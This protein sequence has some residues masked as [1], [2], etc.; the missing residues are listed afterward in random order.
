M[1]Q[2]PAVS[3]SESVLKQKGFLSKL[4][5]FGFS[6]RHQG[7]MSLVYGDTRNSLVNRTG[8]LNNLGIDHRNLVCAKQV[9]GSNIYR[10]EKKDAGRGAFSYE[11]SILDTDAFITD[12]LNLPL[13]IFTADCL[14]VFL[15]DSQR[16]AIGLVHAGWRSSRDDIMVKVSNL[17]RSNFGS[18]P[19]NLKIIFGPAIRS[20][21]YE[22]GKEFNDFFNQGLIEKKEKL[23]LDLV[24]F[25]LRRILDSGVNEE[26]ILDTHICTACQNQDYF[27]F[28]RERKDC[29][30]GISVIMLK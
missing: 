30:R 22:V 16:P 5:S 9:H 18:D 25:N 12:Q 7:N 8:F 13:A 17:M 27:S 26:N 14:S 20:C 11:G 10:A 23:Y 4:L 1:V 19:G 29:G 24:G 15:F 2:N 3:A 6:N 28:R 21:C